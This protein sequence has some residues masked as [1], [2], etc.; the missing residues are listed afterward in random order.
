MNVA[1]SYTPF[2]GPVISP[3][4]MRAFWIWITRAG[5]IS[6]TILFAGLGAGG[7]SGS[8][9]SMKV[10]PPPAIT[11]VGCTTGDDAATRESRCDERFGAYFSSSS[12][13][14]RFGVVTRFA[15]R[16]SF[17][18]TFRLRDFADLESAFELFFAFLA[19][20]SREFFFDDFFL[21][22]FFAVVFFGV[23][24]FFDFA[25]AGRPAIPIAR[26]SAA[27]RERTRDNIVFSTLF[28]SGDRG[29]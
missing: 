15:E 18:V 6:D 10:A 4:E 14:P 19:D 23:D 24:D 2:A 3:C 12:F 5:A 16:S 22:S 27:H 29:L 13:F 17:F 20:A 28:E 21:V 1:W 8:S 11:A 7:A 9:P 25:A 26:I